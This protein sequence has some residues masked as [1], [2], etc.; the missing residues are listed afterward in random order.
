MATKLTTYRI[1][2]R[3]KTDSYRNSVRSMD[4]EDSDGS[5]HLRQ[6]EGNIVEKQIMAVV[7]DYQKTGS[8][9]QT[10]RNMSLST[11]TVRKM[12]VTAGILGNKTIVD[13]LMVR[14][15]HPDWDKVKIAEALNI[16][17]KTV[18][19]YTPYKGMEYLSETVDNSIPLDETIVDSG[20]CGEAAA[21][22]L[23]KSGTL[24]I[25]GVGPMWN[26]S[27]PCYFVWG[28]PRPKWWARRD[29][30]V[31]QKLIV[32]EGITSIGAY[33]FCNLLD[34]AS[35]TLPETIT[36]IEGGSFLGENKIRKFVIPEKVSVIS[37]DTFYTC[38]WMEE[39]HIPAAVCK[40]QTYAF[41]GCVSMKR[42]YFYGDAPKVASS[43]FDMMHKEEV[44][45][46][47][48]EGAV[49]FGEEWQGFRTEVF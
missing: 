21:W 29:G 26:Y 6:C 19:L 23:T 1:E 16:S 35:V 42:L 36:S 47:H 11:G 46:Y 24:T 9:T 34:L 43:T 20:E 10:A 27:G 28:N 32:E 17:V 44:T 38:T 7:E 48:K 4:A 18:E 15:V 8:I 30:I 33:S 40:I 41:H 37:W 5:Q 45:V 2:C 3:V 49:G 25:S 13:I 12:L 31:P 14:T 22:K 39:V